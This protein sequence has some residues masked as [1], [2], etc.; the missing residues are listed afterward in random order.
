MDR[1]KVCR[2]IGS[3]GVALAAA[4]VL[5][6]PVLAD[7]PINDPW[8]INSEGVRLESG[9]LPAPLPSVPDPVNMPPLTL[10]YVN[11]ESWP[12]TVDE[13]EVM[14]LLVR[15]RVEALRQSL[16]ARYSDARLS[17]RSVRNTTDSISAMVGDPMQTTATTG[18]RS[19]T[20]TGMAQEMAQSVS[21]SLGYARAIS[22]IGP[23]GLD[24]VAVFFGL[25]W[26]AFVSVITLL[27]RIIAFLF[28][29]LGKA[30]DGIWKLLILL[31]QVVRLFIAIFD[32]FW[33]L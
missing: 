24:L 7:P 16:S 27:I 4:L 17:V 31:L 10:P 21:F 28:R 22:R 14:K 9:Q 11:H 13:R 1:K 3:C 26:L 2:N 20:L 23:L 29:L 19:V 8:H 15:N 12:T 6:A 5:A 25:G 30:L 32:L 33:P 18:A